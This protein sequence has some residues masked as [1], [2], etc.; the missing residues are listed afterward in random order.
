MMPLILQ[1]FYRRLPS[2]ICEDHKREPFGGTLIWSSSGNNVERVGTDV[3][4]MDRRLSGRLDLA[5]KI[6]VQMFPVLVKRVGW[7]KPLQNIKFS[8]WRIFVC[9]MAA[10]LPL[11]RK[12]WNVLSVTSLLHLLYL[13]HLR[14]NLMY[15][16]VVMILWLRLG[17]SFGFRRDLIISN[18]F[19]NNYLFAV[20][21]QGTVN[22]GQIHQK[23]E[24]DQSGTRL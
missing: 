8:E 13:L 4:R 5:G 20:L 21:L 12:F 19:W 17:V 15:F 11:T 18:M 16:L 7:T 9:Q 2:A 6:F 23:G 14:M 22:R 24:I 3:V 10:S 1:R